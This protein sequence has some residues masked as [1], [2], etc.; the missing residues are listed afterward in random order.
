MG[1]RLIDKLAL[2]SQQVHER[3]DREFINKLFIA[4]RE[5][6]TPKVS[7]QKHELGIETVFRYSEFRYVPSGVA[8]LKRTLGMDK[9]KPSYWGIVLPIGHRKR[10]VL[11]AGKKVF[12]GYRAAKELGLH[13]YANAE[14][15]FEATGMEM[16]ETL[17]VQTMDN[18]WYLLFALPDG[19]ILCMDRELA[20]TLKILEPRRKAEVIVKPIEKTGTGLIAKHFATLINN[21]MFIAEISAKDLII[22][23]QGI[24]ILDINAFDFRKRDMEMNLAYVVGKLWAEGAIEAEELKETLVEGILIDRTM[25]DSFRHARTV[26]EELLRIGKGAS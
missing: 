15:F 16:T 7:Q 13:T 12:V 11:K 3:S 26:A 10:M 4:L 25:M 5:I 6:K 21:R 2:H 17:L 18:E 24:V 14:Q 8:L 1:D 20:I 22:A 9:V 19:K 23:E